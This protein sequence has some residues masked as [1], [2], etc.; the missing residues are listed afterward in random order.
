MTGRNINTY[1]TPQQQ[2]PMIAARNGQKQSAEKLRNVLFETHGAQLSHLRAAI[3]IWVE[4]AENGLTRRF[5]RL[6]P[7]L[8][9]TE[10]KIGFQLTAV[11]DR[12]K[13]AD[14]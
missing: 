12:R 2:Q 9:L 7:A 14:T 8:A 1:R 5:R 11:R 3:P 6:S 10:R 4:D 13:L